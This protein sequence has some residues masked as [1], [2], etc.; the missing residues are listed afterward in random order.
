VSKVLAISTDYRDFRKS[1][2]QEY[3]VVCCFNAV[4]IPPAVNPFH[5]A[6]IGVAFVA[7]SMSLGICLGLD[8]PPFSKHPP[9]SLL[10]LAQQQEQDQIPPDVF[11]EIFHG[12]SP[13]AKPQAGE[14][15]LIYGGRID[16]RCSIL[17]P[18]SGVRQ[19]L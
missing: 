4:K 17:F 13:D 3:A 6:S 11:D 15:V 14:W 2:F 1:A 16:I 5:V 18:D 19:T 8:F 9:L 7:A 12:I 10:S